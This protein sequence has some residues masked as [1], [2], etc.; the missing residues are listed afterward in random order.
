MHAYTFVFI[1]TKLIKIENI[2]KIYTPDT[3]I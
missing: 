1:Q 2:L 3:K